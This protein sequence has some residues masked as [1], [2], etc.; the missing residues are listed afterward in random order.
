MHLSPHA[1]ELELRRRDFHKFLAST[2]YGFVDGWFYQVLCKELQQFMLDVRAK[3]S[4]RLIITVPPRH[5]KSETCSVR[6][7]LYCLLNNPDWEVVV[8]SYGQT[9]AERFSRKAR[10]LIENEHVKSLWRHEYDRNH[11]SVKEWKIGKEM[12]GGTYKAVSRGGALTGAG[13]NCLLVDDPL[14][15]VVEADSKLIRENLWDWYSGVARTRLA[16]GGGVIVVQTRWHEDDLVGRLI[17]EEKSNPEADQW[18]KLEFKAI[19]EEDEQHRKAGEALHPERMNVIELSRTRSSMVPRLWDALYQQR[20]S[21]PGGTII[22]ES[23]IKYYSH[24]DLN[25]MDEMIQT[26]DLR[27]GASQKSGSSYVVGQVWARKGAQYFMLDQIR[28]RMDYVGSRDAIRELSTRYP[29]AIAKLVENKANG[30]AISS[31]L[32]SEI[33]GIVLFEPRGDKIQRLERIA[34]LFMAGNVYI[35]GDAHWTKNYVAELLAFPTA[36]NDDQV[37]ATTQ[38]L[39]WFKERGG[40]LDDII[41]V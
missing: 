34:P 16:P 8:T 5:L 24:I 13:A 30:P 23:W 15:D 4:P 32:A 33:D 22:K 41:F 27:F 29:Q 10:A 20:P 7:P 35:C 3:K 26:W 2:F 31:D 37:D 11:F 6:F 36:P 25:D 21:R 14:K 18:C 9:L 38:A 17:A 12:Q 19:A 28:D 40:E 1:I 39:A